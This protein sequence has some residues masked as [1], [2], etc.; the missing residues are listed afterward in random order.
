[1]KLLFVDNACH[2]WK[3]WSNRL[4]VLLSFAIA[5]VWNDPGMFSAAVNLLPAETRAFLSPV[6]IL[7]AAGIPILTRMIAQP[8]LVKDKT[9]GE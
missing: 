1:V 3:L 9:D 6:V 5:A 2:W 7:I 8:K 4:A